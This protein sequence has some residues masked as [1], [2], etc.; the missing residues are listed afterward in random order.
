MLK[1]YRCRK[2][3]KRSTETII[4]WQD[5]RLLS[6]QNIKLKFNPP[7][8]PWKEEVWESL[9]E[10]VKQT[11]RVIT[12]DGAFTKDSLTTFLWK[13]ESV[14]NQRPLSPTSDNIDDL[15]DIAPYHFLLGSSSSN[16]PPGSFN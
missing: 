15:D 10:S 14:I 8:S 12:R 2:A 1:F 16:L 4:S 9:A 13:V 3:A 5:Y 7:I 11:L 6:R